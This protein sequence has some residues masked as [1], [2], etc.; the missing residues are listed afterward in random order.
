MAMRPAAMFIAGLLLLAAGAAGA[1]APAGGD[2]LAFGAHPV[3]GFSV[4]SREDRVVLTWRP[5]AD[6]NVHRL[7]VFR[8]DMDRLGDPGAGAWERLAELAA[9]ATSFVDTTAPPGKRYLYLLRSLARD[10]RIVGQSRSKAGGRVD[11]VPPAA[12]AGLAASPGETADRVVLTWRPV[13]DADVLFYRVMRGVAGG[14]SRVVDLP[15][16]PGRAPRFVDRLPANPGYRFR[17]AVRTVDSSGNLSPLSAEVVFQAA[18]HVAPPS[19]VLTRLTAEA[20]ALIVAWAASSAPDTVGYRVYRRGPADKAF[21][22]ISGL[23]AATRYR[24]ETVRG[25]AEYRYRVTAVDRAGNESRPSRAYTKRALGR[26]RQW[27]PP[28]PRVASDK[29]GR[30]WLRW[31]E[32]AGAPGYLVFRSMQRDGVYEPVSALLRQA[33]FTDSRPPAGEVVWYRVRVMDRNGRLS[34]PSAP[35]AW[36]RGGK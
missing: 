32:I 35:V 24:D 13:A 5:V 2:P 29:R 30:P 33:A 4:D 15:A 31:P 12:P 23:V 28:V 26:A 34:P 25:G 11:K 8:L 18:D 20:G 27:D 19:P 14:L 21:V 36:R 7:A 9:D 22:R 16:R 3:T 6:G 10:G 17:Y 1:Q